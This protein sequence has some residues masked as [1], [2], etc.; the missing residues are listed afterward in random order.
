VTFPTVKGNKVHAGAGQHPINLLTLVF[1]LTFFLPLNALKAEQSQE[2]PLEKITIAFSSVS[3]N[4]APLWITQEHGFFR[5]Y[6]LDVQSVFIE[7]GRTTVQSLI[8]KEVVFAQMAGAGVLQSRLG[9]SDVVLIAGFLNTMDYQL[10]V[11]KSIT[12]PDQLKGKIMAV[13]RFGSSSDF[14]TRYA[15][16][17]FGLVP[18]RDVTILEIGSQP[19]R[20]AA[21]ESGKIQ[22]AM[23]AIPLTRKA[24]TLGFHTL[25]D[26]QMVG[27]EYQ[28]TGLATTQALIRTRPDLVRNVMKAY[29]EG[30]HY[31][32]TRRAGSLGVLAKYLKTPNIEVL[33]EVYENLGINL[34]PQKPYP[35]LR[36][37]EIMLRELAARDPK[38]KGAKP[39][40]FVNLT[41]IK[42]LDSSG[43][44]DRLYKT[45]PAVAMREA[46]LGPAAVITQETPAQASTKARP[47][48]EEIKAVSTPAA[49]ATGSGEYTVAPGDTLSYLALKYYGDQYKW[50]KIYEANKQTMRDPHSLYV[51]QKITI[52]LLDG[53]LV[54]EQTLPISSHLSDYHLERPVAGTTNVLELR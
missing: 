37:I 48:R 14:A 31:Y 10:M 20:F 41:F 38:A 25:A 21:L 16:D 23:V 52:P 13:S 53:K 2:R 30:I 17:K 47:A 4:M 26:L 43:F 18:E 5:K 12:R 46:P 39:E 27:L 19:A 34:T 7:S 8:S 54:G 36:G 29:V 50:E 15:L 33:M 9:G 51:G 45:P 32:K 1:L 3:A 6:G 35:T 49:S 28:H 40:E 22:A 44:I 42:E 11:D 24:K